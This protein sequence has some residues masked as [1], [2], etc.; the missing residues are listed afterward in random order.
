MSYRRRTA[1][2]FAAGT[3]NC[4]A[5]FAIAASASIAA[6]SPM[7]LTFL[8]A[9]SSLSFAVAACG[10][11]WPEYRAA[12]GIIE[13]NSQFRTLRGILAFLA[14]NTLFN[15]EQ[16]YDRNKLKIAGDRVDQSNDV[17]ISCSRETQFPK[18][19]RIE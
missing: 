4:S 17:L 7:G 9:V 5:A 6:T 14:K 19:I 13:P 16:R 11:A 3:L 2:S 18:H 12:D 10:R 8:P 15:F 1:I